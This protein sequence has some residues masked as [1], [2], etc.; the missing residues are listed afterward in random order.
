MFFSRYRGC[1]FFPA[2]GKSNQK[3]P[4]LRY[5][6]LKSVSGLGSCYPQ[7]ASIR[8]KN[9]HAKVLKEQ[10]PSLPTAH[11]SKAQNVQTA[12]LPASQNGA[13]RKFEKRHERFVIGC[14]VLQWVK[15]TSAY[16]IC[17]LVATAG[18]TFSSSFVV[19]FLREFRRTLR[20]VFYRQKK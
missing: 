18:L 8:R 16:A 7:G 17:S 13:L 14:F 20:L 12:P 5:L 2:A 10:Q 3:E 9:I 19:C 11:L 1:H 6:L 15:K 4:P